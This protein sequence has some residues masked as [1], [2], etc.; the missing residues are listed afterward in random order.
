MHMVNHKQSVRDETRLA[1]WYDN[2]DTWWGR[3]QLKLLGSICDLIR[4][5]QELMAG[6]KCATIDDFTPCK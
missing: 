6:G 2:A 1:T 3:P 5:S 4:G